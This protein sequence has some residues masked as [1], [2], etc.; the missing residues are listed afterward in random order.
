MFNL[1]VTGFGYTEIWEISKSLTPNGQSS[2]RVKQ[3]SIYHH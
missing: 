1:A 2:E 3:G